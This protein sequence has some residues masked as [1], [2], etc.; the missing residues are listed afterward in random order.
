MIDNLEHYGI[1]GCVSDGDII[2]KIVPKF[3]DGE[4]LELAINFL[5]KEGDTEQDK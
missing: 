5:N 3:K 1:V 4:I 2:E